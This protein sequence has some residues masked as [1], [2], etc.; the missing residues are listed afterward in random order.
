MPIVK[1][2]APLTPEGEYCGQ[3]RNVRQ[4]YVE[5][6]NTT[7]NL[8]GKKPTITIFRIPIHL[9]EGKSITTVIRFQESTLWV[10]DQVVKS[11]GLLLPENGEDYQITPDDLEGR[12]AYFGIEHATLKDGRTVQ[13]VKWHSRVYA[14]QQNPALADVKFN[15]VPLP[16]RLRAVE[17]VEEP[18]P[19]SAPAVSEPTVTTTSP[20]GEGDSR[21][22]YDLT[23]QERQE[24]L[25]YAARLRKERVSQNPPVPSR[26]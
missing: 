17:R 25:E 8:D 22:L 1:R 14:L 20:V 18:A 10:L 16:R 11:L 23:P 24:A 26:S 15:N 12:V 2:S 13:N 19:A 7:P 4:D 9:P 6:K 3:I 21:E 5:A